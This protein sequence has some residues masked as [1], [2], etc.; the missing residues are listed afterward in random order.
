M[1]GVCP[2][3]RSSQRS[4]CGPSPDTLWRG[5]ATPPGVQRLSTCLGAHWLECRLLSASFNP[6]LRPCGQL[7]L[8]RC[9]FL[10]WLFGSSLVASRTHPAVECALVSFTLVWAPLGPPGSGPRSELVPQA[11]ILGRS[12]QV[13]PLRSPSR[14]LQAE[15]GTRG[16]VRNVLAGFRAGVVG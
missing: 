2:R 1:Q 13:L 14:S 9:Y 4:P 5:C 11:L 6:R 7:L 16:L 15:L 10:R 12:L 8:S 3:R